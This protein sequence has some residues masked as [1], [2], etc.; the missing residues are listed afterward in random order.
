M[1]RLTPPQGYVCVTP[2]SP[3]LEE[4]QHIEALRCFCKS[5]NISVKNFRGPRYTKPEGAP[6]SAPATER[7]YYAYCRRCE[8][9]NGGSREDRCNYGVRSVVPDGANVTHIDEHGECRGEAAFR[10]GDA[11][12]PMTVDQHNVLV[13]EIERI[14]AERVMP[15][16][17]I[18]ALEKADLPPVTGDS[19][20]NMIKKRK[21]RERDD[22]DEAASVE[23]VQQW[24]DVREVRLDVDEP[25]FPDDASARLISLALGAA[26]DEGRKVPIVNRGGVVMA[27][28]LLAFINHI[29][30][31]ASPETLKEGLVGQV[32]HLYKI[33][34]QSYTLGILGVQL[35]QLVREE[36]AHL[37]VPVLC[38]LAP[39]ESHQPYA[40]LIELSQLL[41]LAVARR[42]G[43]QLNPRVFY[44]MHAD[45][46]PAARR[47]LRDFSPDCILVN[48]LEHM[49]RNLRRCSDDD[50]TLRYSDIPVYVV[51][52]L[53]HAA[54]L[55]WGR[56]WGS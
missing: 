33:V 29:F 10:R 23:G 44:Q 21:R 26:G 8:K 20:G 9:P 46:A 52:V 47:A 34:W 50:S 45:F 25:A 24:S 7:T 39:T 6:R 30:D 16:D 31:V 35:Y 32:D 38:V 48:D 37:F 53:R 5:R 13:S 18:K 36:W 27:F 14:G 2:E 19:I 3:E 54:E 17:L 11:A 22:P 42:R 56:L 43:A 28:A 4:H 55:P 40:L 51:F 12:H 15:T 1:R 49:Y 41:L